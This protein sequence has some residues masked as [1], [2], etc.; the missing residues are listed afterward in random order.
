MK[1]QN[2][3][4][5]GKTILCI[6]LLE[7][8]IKQFYSIVSKLS[9]N[10]EVKLAFEYLSADSEIHKD[11]LRRIAKLLAPSLKFET[12][13]NCEVMVGSKLMEALKK[14]EDMLNKMEKRALGKEDITELIRWHISLSGPEYLMMVNLTAFSF[15]LKRRKGVSQILKAMAE[16]RKARIEVQEQIIRAIGSVKPPHNN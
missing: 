16:G 13:E 11:F 1:N 3:A 4:E 14:Y 7:E 6:S 10:E 5:I 2:F 12:I 15:I 9:E 8:K